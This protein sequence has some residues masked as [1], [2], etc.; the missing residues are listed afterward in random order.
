MI[1]EAYGGRCILA[2]TAGTCD[3]YLNHQLKGAS[4]FSRAVFGVLA[5]VAALA[6]SAGGAAAQQKLKV[7]FI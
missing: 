6:L 4:M 2:I 3:G 1:L 5:G 7:G